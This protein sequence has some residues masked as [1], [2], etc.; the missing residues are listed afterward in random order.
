MEVLCIFALELL[1]WVLITFHGIPVYY[2]L[3]NPDQVILCYQNSNV[4]FKSRFSFL[5]A[6][7]TW[8]YFVLQGVCNIARLAY[9]LFLQPFIL[10]VA[11][12][13]YIIL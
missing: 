4:I 1:T 5:L 13:C 2:F 11:L 8:M 10:T 9:I 7:L 3:W 6:F 12:F